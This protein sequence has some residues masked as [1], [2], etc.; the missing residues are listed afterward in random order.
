MPYN[1]YI[2][3]REVIKMSRKKEYFIVLDTE[4][5]NTIEQPLCYDIGWCVCDRYG[6]IYERKS[7]VVAE[8]FL[9]MKD[10]MKSAYYADKIPQYWEDIKSGNRTVARMWTI[11]KALINSMK[12]YDVKKV[13][14]YN[15]AFDKRALNN[16][17]RY[18]SKSW[19][20]WFFPYGTEFFDIWNCAC[21]LILARKSYIDFAIKNG[22][23]SSCDK[24]LTSAECAY[25]YITKNL[26]FKEEHK[27]LEDCEI[28]VAILAECYKQHK[29]MDT[30]INPS[31]WRKVQRKRR[32]LD[33]R[34]VFA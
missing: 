29:K 30:T 23:V 17:M 18:V 32:E 4:T 11:R 12:Q 25:K 10:V 24:I 13:G 16:L 6:K 21:E 15:M 2:K 27:G 20:R 14:A 33:L 1:E 28:E 34:E 7:F 19:C 26:D 9:D 5:C 8:T 3:T 22:L 31:C